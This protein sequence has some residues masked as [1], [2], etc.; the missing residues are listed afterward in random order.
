[1]GR[2]EGEEVTEDYQTFLESKRKAHVDCGFDVVE[3]L[4]E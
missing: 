3:E 4:R 1:M 2:N